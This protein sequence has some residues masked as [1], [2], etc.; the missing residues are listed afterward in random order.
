MDYLI[1]RKKLVFLRPLRDFLK[2]SLQLFLN[3]VGLG[4]K[5]NIIYQKDCWITVTKLISL[6]KPR[7][8]WDVG[9]NRGDW[10]EVISDLNE[11][12]KQIVLFEPQKEFMSKLKAKKK[13]GIDLHVFP[14]GLGDKKETLFLKGGSP[15]ASFMDSLNT[16]LNYFPGSLNKNVKEKVMIDTIDGIFEKNSL[17]YPDLIKIDVQGFEL[18]V[19]K[20][21]E[22]VL[23]YVKYLVIELSLIDFYKGQPKLDEIIEFLKKRNFVLIEFGNVLKSYTVPKEILQFDAIFMNTKVK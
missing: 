17:I 6:C 12:L 18:K 15:S 10:F 20:G 22:K 11:N 5:I 19:L 8:Y 2:V 9:A 16:Q 4:S 13:K 7:V 14:I 21:G 23:P 1:L 3:K